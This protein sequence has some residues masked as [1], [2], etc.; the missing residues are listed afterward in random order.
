MRFSIL[1]ALIV[2][3]IG[4]TVSVALAAGRT[5]EPQPPGAD[6]HRHPQAA[7]VKNP[8]TADAKSIAAG[9][10]IYAKACATCHGDTGKGD[11]SM[12]EEL[13]PKPSNLVDAEWKHGPTD[14]EIFSLIRDGSKGTGMQAYRRKLS[15]HE[16]W[17][18]VNYIR[19][20]GPR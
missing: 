8:V 9:K 19:S 3:T 5:Q 4:A 13:T 14:G 7:K 18:T 2:V 10:A 1:H 17:D 11:G 6:A 15:A 20:I 12:G 16:I